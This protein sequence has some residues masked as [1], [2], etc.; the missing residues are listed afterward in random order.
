VFCIWI[1]CWA[2]IIDGNIQVWAWRE[3]TLWACYE[4]YPWYLQ[5]YH[6]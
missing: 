5:I 2:P 4:L 6:F 3:N 1:C